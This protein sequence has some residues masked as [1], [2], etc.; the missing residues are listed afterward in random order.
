[1]ELVVVVFLDLVVDLLGKVEV[2]VEVAGSRI[3][4]AWADREVLVRL[5]LEEPLA[6]RRAVVALGHLLDEGV[7]LALVG[8]LAFE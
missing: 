6:L 5:L 2:A 8:S 4:R 7:S 1:M 3:A